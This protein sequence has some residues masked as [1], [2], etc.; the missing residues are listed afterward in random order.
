MPIRWFGLSVDGSGG[1]PG[2]GGYGH[3]RSATIEVGANGTVSTGL[4]AAKVGNTTLCSG[5]LSNGGTTTLCSC[6]GSGMRGTLCSRTGSRAS[7]GGAGGGGGATW[8]EARSWRSWTRVG[9]RSSPVRLYFLIACKK[10][11]I[12][13]IKT[14]CV[15]SGGGVTDVSGNHA[16]VSATRFARVDVTT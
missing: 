14:S 11:L 4:A 10:S 9:G 2:A 13:A 16:T 6:T 8:S 7:S 5:T 3:G 12:A 15:S 1:R